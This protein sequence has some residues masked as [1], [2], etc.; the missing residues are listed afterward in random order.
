[1]VKF[2]NIYLNSNVLFKKKKKSLSFNSDIFQQNTGI[3]SITQKDTKWET[4]TQDQPSWI[5]SLFIFSWRSLALGTSHFQTTSY[6]VAFW[7]YKGSDQLTPGTPGLLLFLLGQLPFLFC[8]RVTILW[9][10]EFIVHNKS[11][12]LSYTK[13][14]LWPQILYWNNPAADSPLRTNKTFYMSIKFE[15]LK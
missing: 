9:A 5:K 13:G 11:Q 6:L 4:W 12:R 7:Q 10:N 1:M 8:T 2:F 3:I 15:K 14:T